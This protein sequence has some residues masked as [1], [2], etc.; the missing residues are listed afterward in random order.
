MIEQTL[1]EKLE[2]LVTEHLGCEGTPGYYFGYESRLK[3]IGLAAVRHFR[4]LKTPRPI[5]SKELI[6]RGD[7]VESTSA[8]SL[9]GRT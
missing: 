4:G 6:E 9:Q 1:E 5:T 3:D 8:V 2:S 7:R